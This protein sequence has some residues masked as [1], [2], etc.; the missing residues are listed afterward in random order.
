MSRFLIKN[1]YLKTPA[2][3]EVF[4]KID[5]R[6]F[7]LPKYS[8]YAYSNVPLPIGNGQNISQPLIAAFML[9][10]LTPQKGEKILEIGSGSG[11]Q[12]ALLAELVG[13]EG[14]VVT[15]EI[16]SE[17]KKITEENL[18]K[19][20][21]LEKGIVKVILGDGSL[22]WVGEAPFDKIIV[23]GRAERIFD[24]WKSQLRLGG[25]LVAPIRD[26]IVFLEK[27]ESDCF[28]EKNFFGFKFA[29]L[30]SD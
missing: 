24:D 6:D 7:V 3:I 2:I 5:R 17:L 29:P 28:L 1:G 14:K 25:R 22:G 10:L 19:Y 13:E 27:I 11:W 30:K 20:G 12:T 8:G 23:S 26:N 21:F 16:D 4:Q 15:I 18:E 9:E